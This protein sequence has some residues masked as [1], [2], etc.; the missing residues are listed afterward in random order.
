M[1]MSW[2]MFVGEIMNDGK[3]MWNVMNAEKGS[4]DRQ[5]DAMMTEL[6][7]VSFFIIPYPAAA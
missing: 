1:S 3:V 2:N 7:M 6:S 5:R 4:I